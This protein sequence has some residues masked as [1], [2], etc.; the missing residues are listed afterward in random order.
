M[1]ISF[2]DSPEYIRRTK[3]PFRPPQASLA[4]VRAVVPKHLFEKNTLRG[5]LYV[6]RDVTC[7]LVFYELGWRIDPFAQACGQS[8]SPVVAS[9]VRCALWATY[10][11]FQSLAFSGWWCLAHEAGHGTLS[12][13]SWI[14][15]VVG[16]TLH[17]FLLVPYYAWRSS[18]HSHH[19]ATQS[20]ERDE[21]YLPKTRS[22]Y[23]IPAEH[24]AHPSDYHEI[25]EETPI[26][27]LIRMIVMQAIGWNYYLL[28]NIMGNP[29]YPPGTNH[30]RPSS[31]LFKPHERSKIVASNV[32]LAVMASLLILWTSHVGFWSFV[33][34]YLV[35]YILTNHWI[36]MLTYLHH[37]DPTLPH[38]RSKEWTFLRG[39]VST[40]DRPLLGWLGRFFL[41]NVSHDHVAHHLFS[42]IPFYNQPYVTEA[43]KTVLQDDYNYDSTNSFRAL[44]RTFSQCCFIEDDGDIVFYKNKDGKAVRILESDLKRD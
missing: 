22:D 37:S 23:R 34:F 21:N 8:L 5:M 9:I 26:Y 10:W 40:V 4:E 14:N 31:A 38:Y 7:V 17:T 29:S 32:G 16:F 28:T 41:H 36:V 33:R 18:H 43:I 25:F 24:I 13:I 12:S 42:T 39:A 20:L 15:H 19:K 2:S 35:P 11:L 3:K 44:Y 30:F 1:L 27:T 6:V